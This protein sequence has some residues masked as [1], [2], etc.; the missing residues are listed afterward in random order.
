MAAPAVVGSESP[1]GQTRCSPQLK[2]RKCIVSEGTANVEPPQLTTWG[3]KFDEM[4]LGI[5]GQICRKVG[6]IKE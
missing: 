4:A 2:R 3:M 5:D 6:R 1:Q